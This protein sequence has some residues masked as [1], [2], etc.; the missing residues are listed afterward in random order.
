M[1]GGTSGAMSA[2]HKNGGGVERCGKAGIAL[3]FDEDEHA[4]AA[5][6]AEAMPAISMPECS[7]IDKLGSGQIRDLSRRIPA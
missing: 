7:R 6:A 1:P 2:V 4:L 3:A 5:S